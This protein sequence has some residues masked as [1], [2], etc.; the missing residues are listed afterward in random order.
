[1]TLLGAAF[2]L[3]GVAKALLL[4]DP[5]G[6]NADPMRDR[7]WWCLARFVLVGDIVLEFP[8]LKQ[9]IDVN[10]PMVLMGHFLLVNLIRWQSN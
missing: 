3:E 5:Q 7:Q 8:S 4:S 9:A 1:M 10:E 2:L 6:E